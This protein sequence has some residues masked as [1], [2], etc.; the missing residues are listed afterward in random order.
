MIVFPVSCIAS[1][2][3]HLQQ[4]RRSSHKEATSYFFILFEVLICQT[5]KLIYRANDYPTIVEST[6][7]IELK[8]FKICN[9]IGVLYC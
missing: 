3:C 2:K 9:L 6:H 1:Y 4:I 5:W 8:L 7:L